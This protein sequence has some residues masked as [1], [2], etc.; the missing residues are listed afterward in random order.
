MLRKEKAMKRGSLGN[1]KGAE[2]TIDLKD[3][4]K[5]PKSTL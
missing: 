4:A 2:H 1:N 5:P 3:G